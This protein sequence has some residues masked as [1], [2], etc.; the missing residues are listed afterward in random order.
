MNI[1]KLVIT[2]LSV[3][4]S[5]CYICFMNFMNLYIFVFSDNIFVIYCMPTTLVLEFVAIFT[6]IRAMKKK[7]I[8]E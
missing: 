4:L 7:T 2:K 8:N 3:F 5:I 6:L 1:N